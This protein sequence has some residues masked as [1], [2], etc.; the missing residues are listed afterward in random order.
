M[1]SHSTNVQALPIKVVREAVPSV[2]EM[3]EQLLAEARRGEIRALAFA[4]VHEGFWIG[5]GNA[6]SQDEPVGPALLGAVTQLQAR[7]TFDG[8]QE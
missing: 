1:E 8:L 7:L 6:A 2:V 4:T 5:T 3:L